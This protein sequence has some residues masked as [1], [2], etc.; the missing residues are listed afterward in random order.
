[1][2]RFIYILAATLSTM[3]S[4]QE[5]TIDSQPDAPLS[6]YIDALDSYSLAGTAPGKI[7]FNISSNTP[8]T[9]KS[10]SQWCLPSPA[11]SASSSLVSEIIVNTEDNPDVTP[12]TATLVINAE[13]L[14]DV[15]TITVEQGEKIETE[16]EEPAV[17]EVEP[18]AFD[19]VFAEG[20]SYTKDP[21]TGYVK[22]DLSAGE[23]FR[24][25]Y[26]V[27]KGRTVIELADMKM[28]AIC[29]LGFSFIAA[30]QANYK[31]HLEGNNTYWFR[32]AGGFGWV[33]PIKKTYTLEEVNAIR[34]LEFVVEDDP[35]AAGKLKISIY[36]ND[37]LY[38]SQTG[39]TDVFAA[40]DPGCYFIFEAGTAPAE[41]DYCTF[42]SIN[43]INE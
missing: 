36:I 17:P 10:D 18:A 13:E 22:V 34:K 14:G 30:S 19:V 16:P 5:L 35:D 38:G 43:Y 2:K 4:C 39:R 37:A 3:L 42:K 29:N 26:P 9:I 31:L 25:A 24:T 15:K 32:C 23:M 28:S 20:V 11:M 12:R 1:M 8:W 41:G 40:G 27:T 6:I 33:A 7:V 21:V